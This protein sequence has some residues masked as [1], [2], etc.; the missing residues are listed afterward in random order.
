MPTLVP[1]DAVPKLRPIAI[2]IVDPVGLHVSDLSF[3]VGSRQTRFKLL[4]RY[5]KKS[6]DCDNGDAPTNWVANR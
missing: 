2:C 6:H 5:L 1:V 4:L 3:R